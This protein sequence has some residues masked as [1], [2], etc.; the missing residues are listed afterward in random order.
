[1]SMMV[2]SCSYNERA[3]HVIAENIQVDLNHLDVDSVPLSM[4]ADSVSLLALETTEEALIGRISDV[5]CTTKG[6]IIADKKFSA[7]YLYDYNGHFLRKIGNRGQ[8]PGEYFN[9]L[10]IDATD[11][12]IYA[13]DIVSESVN[14]Y[15]YDGHYLGRD[16][17]GSFD[18]FKVLDEGRR[19]LAASFNMGD[20]SGVFL[21]TPSPEYSKTKLIGR[22]DPVEINHP[23]EFYNFGDTVNVMSSAFEDNLYCFQA[24]SLVKILELDA[25]PQPSDSEIELWT[26][27]DAQ[28]HYLRTTYLN[29]PNYYIAYY[30]RYPD[31]RVAILDKRNKTIQ[32]TSEIYND[33]T[34]DDYLKTR[35][36]CNGM[37]IFYISGEDEDSNPRLMFL[38]LK[39]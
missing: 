26:R 21:I 25:K 3:N 19:Y 23:W 6:I 11:S 1:M 14:K 35:G 30:S 16:R 9:L 17:I 12:Y 32:V 22:R 8:G 24:D 27:P 39:E 20:S 13:Y 38:H 5:R 7:V 29:F 15:D 28:N 18:D 36:I 2:T 4:F 34:G 10:G 37:P 33:F 31:L